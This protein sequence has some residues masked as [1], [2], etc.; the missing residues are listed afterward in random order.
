MINWS[1]YFYMQQ[2][3][4]SGGAGYVLSKT[5]LQIFVSK[6]VENKT[7]QVCGDKFNTPED[8]Q[9]GKCL[10]ALQVQCK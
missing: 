1:I 6:G 8:V 9:M 2:G 5:A 7:F 4:M 10:E 3:Y